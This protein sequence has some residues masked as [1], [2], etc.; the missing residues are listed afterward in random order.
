MEGRLPAEQGGTI[1]ADGT[2]RK[3]HR[4][5]TRR[6]VNEISTTLPPTGV[7]EGLQEL[8]AMV[9]F[10]QRPCGD[11]AAVTEAASTWAGNSRWTYLRKLE[12][13]TSTPWSSRSR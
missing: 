3:S 13:F 10:G 2:H 7:C 5:K 9:G 1:P 8:Q 4:R 11:Q 12:I 6:D